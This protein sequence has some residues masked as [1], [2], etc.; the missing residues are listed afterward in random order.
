MMFPLLLSII[1]TLFLVGSR[2]VPMDT[3][4]HAKRAADSDFFATCTDININSLTAA[5]TATCQTLAGTEVES[6]IGLDSCIANQNGVLIA[7]SNGNFSLTCP[8]RTF[9]VTTTSVTLTAECFTLRERLV[10]STID[11]NT[12]LTN[13]N[14]V[15]SCP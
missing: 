11:L 3:C 8:D 7:E 12:I 1:C 9:L 5:L 2:G 6:S 10:N 4:R 14:G 13:Q 15:M